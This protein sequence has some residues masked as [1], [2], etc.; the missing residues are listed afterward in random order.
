LA[1][2]G[3]TVTLLRNWSR[4]GQV[5]RDDGPWTVAELAAALEALDRPDVMADLIAALEEGLG[6]SG[7]AALVSYGNAVLNQNPAD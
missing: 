1:V 3:G 7:A 5:Q 6:P 2:R 4:D